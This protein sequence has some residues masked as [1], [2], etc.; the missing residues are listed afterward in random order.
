MSGTV[1]GHTFSL[2]L[3]LLVCVFLCAAIPSSVQAQLGMGVGQ[4]VLDTS[5]SFPLPNADVSV[6]L[7][8]YSVNA[9]G[10]EVFWFIDGV[11]QTEVKN[12]RSI[13]LKAG[14]VGEETVVRAILR[15]QD[16]SDVAA[17]LTIAPTVVDLVLEADT[18]VP[19]FYKGRSL[20]SRNS[21]LSAVALVHD[22]KSVAS[23]AYT[24]RWTLGEDVLFAGSVRGK[25][26]VSFEMPLFSKDLVVEVLNE[27]GST[28]GRRSMKIEAV[29]PELH[30]Y[31]WS[32]LR[33]LYQRE[34]SNPF[35]LIG[36]ETVIHGEP[37][38][39]TH[40][41]SRET[42]DFMWRID[43]MAVSPNAEAAQA[44]GLT[45]EGLGNGQI[46]LRLVTKDRVPAVLEK[47]FT[48][49]AN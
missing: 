40:A 3:L 8:D 39:V 29:Q 33:G 28:V 44:F 6:R 31:E 47:S 18:Y 13:T 5:P 16:G 24:Y 27:S 32:P 22:G 41:P 19:S 46:S 45:K 12:A 4:L 49:I 37:Y 14:A 1:Y 20:P 35:A 9:V 17:S 38:F 34:A 23:N 2:R 25:S 7:E 43:G 15:K 30:F 36:E 11:E 10:A 48:V 42:T 26:R 21:T